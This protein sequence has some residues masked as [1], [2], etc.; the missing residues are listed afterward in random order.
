MKKIN[1][2]NHEISIFKEKNET[3]SCGYM[4]KSSELIPQKIWKA[5]CVSRGKGHNSIN[6]LVQHHLSLTWGD[7]GA[8]TEAGNFQKH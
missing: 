3:S 4:K 8:T 2:S 5:K 1:N 6:P 7:P